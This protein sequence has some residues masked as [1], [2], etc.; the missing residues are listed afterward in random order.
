MDRTS[1]HHTDLRTPGRRFPAPSL[2]EPADARR[3]SPDKGALRDALKVVRALDSDSYQALLWALGLTP[4]E[5]LSVPGCA[6]G[7]SPGDQA[8]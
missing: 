3:F 2:A 7:Q 4:D 5:R 1:Q 6:R 8:A